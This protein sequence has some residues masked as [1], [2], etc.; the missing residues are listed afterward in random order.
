[1]SLDNSYADI[2]VFTKGRFSNNLYSYKIPD[3]LANKIRIG[4]VVKV[5]FNNSYQEG[6]VYELFRKSDH[7]Q[8]EIKE[9]EDY[10]FQ[11]DETLIRYAKL[12]S[13]YYINP[14]GHTISNYLYEFLNKKSLSPENIYSKP[15][16]IFDI[17]C[18]MDLC[19][20]IS[21]NKINIVYCPSIKAIESL[22]L[23]LIDND[24][25]ITYRQSTGGKGEKIIVTDLINKASKGV[26]IILNT[27][28]Y[29]P[30]L[31]KENI[32]FHYWDI[33]NFKYKESRKPYFNLIDVANIQSRFS[34]HKQFFY[35]E[36]PN[37]QFVKNYIKIN[38]SIPKLDIKYF[39]DTDIKNAL[40]GFLRNSK[41]L[42]L[43]NAVFNLTYCSKEMKEDLNKIIHEFTIPNEYL[44]SNKVTDINVLVE[45]SISYNGVLN[46]DTL[47]SLIRYLNIIS[48]N[49]SKIYVITSKNSAILSLLN[50]V[51]INKWTKKEF[52]YRNKYGPSHLLKIVNVEADRP[53]ELDILNLIGPIKDTHTSTY[54]YQLTY[55]INDVFETNYFDKLKKYNYSFINYF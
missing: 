47:S 14:V 38:N 49:S 11:S 50:D 31:N 3:K 52:E 33:N 1:M 43:D 6:V 53:L 28:I 23:Y 30:F 44:E 48:K 22:S 40:L 15:E 2:I 4:S 5:P 42:E 32:I 45:P 9:I 26:F 19:N 35:G 55:S 13:N 37:Y 7:I 36:F 46:S 29:N 24:I 18:R 17:D 20:N 27:L 8:F 41:D 21:E 54:K 12:L 34:N 25:E 10:I 51:N 16:Y 39:Y